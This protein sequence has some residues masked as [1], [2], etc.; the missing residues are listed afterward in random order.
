MYVLHVHTVR[1]SVYR[2]IISASANIHPAEC[3]DELVRIPVHIG[4]CAK[5]CG[6]GLLRAYDH[7]FIGTVT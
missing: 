7:E 5:H 2:S 3:V 6:E 1:V 4:G